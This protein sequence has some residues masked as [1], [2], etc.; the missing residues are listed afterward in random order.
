[1]VLF[2]LFYH[3]PQSGLILTLLWAPFFL[4]PLELYQYA[5]PMTEVMILI[6]SGACLLKLFVN[7]GIELQL[8]NS[9]YPIFSMAQLKQRLTII[10][11]CVGMIGVIAVISLFWTRYLDVAITELR[12]LILEPIL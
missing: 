10:D 3:R 2:V 7:W 12:T 4:F 6:T 1:Y 8:Q 5:F 9:A 11:I